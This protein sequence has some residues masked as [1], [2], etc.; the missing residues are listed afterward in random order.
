MYSEGMKAKPESCRYTQVRSQVKLSIYFS[1]CES[2]YIIFNFQIF[3]SKSIFLLKG[4]LNIKY[5]TF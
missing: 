3:C 5:Y 2:N 4:F 1:G